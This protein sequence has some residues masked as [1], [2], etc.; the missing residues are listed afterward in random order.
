MIH[1]RFGVCG[2]ILGT[3]PVSHLSHEARDTKKLLW[4]NYVP[5]EKDN[6]FHSRYESLLC[7]EYKNGFLL[8]SFFFQLF[9]IC[10]VCSFV[11]WKYW[12]VK[13]KVCKK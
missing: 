11:D 6:W 3:T 1:V 5:E 9:H 8:V 13:P 12:K 2:V 7:L 4:F 10:F